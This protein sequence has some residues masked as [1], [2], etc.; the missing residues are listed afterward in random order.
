[1]NNPKSNGGSYTVEYDDQ[2]QVGGEVQ[3]ASISTIEAITRAEIDIQI[4]TARAYPRKIS[5]F[6]RD[7]TE[8]ATVDEETAES[9]IFNRP[10]GSHYDPVTKK[11]IIDYA[12]GMSI[13]M[14]EIVAATYSNI[15]VGS[16]IIEQS[17]RVV[18]ARG[19]CHDLQ[20]NVMQFAEVAESTVTSGG[21]PYSERMRIV[22]AKA[23]LRKAERD[24]TFK[25]IPR[26][27]CR[28]I[29]SAVRAIIAGDGSVATITKRRAKVMGWISK[30]GINVVRVYAALDVA[31]ESD[32]GIEA[33]DRLTA[34]KTALGDKE[35]TVD[36]AFPPIAESLNHPI[37]FHGKAANGKAIDPNL[38][39]V[40]KINACKSEADLGALGNLLTQDEFEHN[41]ALIETAK[42]RLRGNMDAASAA[43]IAKAEA[44]TETL[45]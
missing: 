33:L 9:C 20:R 28:P 30:L 17:D 40:A 42:A 4:A 26:A 34:I 11:K 12:D 45:V 44:K 6:L 8:I 14:A 24:A 7:A 22:V 25:V 23:T 29:E 10:V 27:I 16:M 5:E 19:F 3:V 38:A 15:R 1:M 43:K 21:Q 2:S 36:E 37:G 35:Y 39:L 18:R 41:S 13:R 32:L 31:G